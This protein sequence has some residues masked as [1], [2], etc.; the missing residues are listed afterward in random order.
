MTAYELCFEYVEKLRVAVYDED[1]R[2]IVKTLLK[3]LANVIKNPGV[4]KYRL[5]RKSNNS[6]RILTDLYPQALEILT[7]VGFEEKTID[8]EQKL[9][10]DAQKE[11]KELMETGLKV[12]KEAATDLNMAPG[13]IPQVSS[14]NKAQ[15]DQA[16]TEARESSKNKKNFNL[17]KS[18]VQN[19]SGTLTGN[20]SNSRM[21]DEVKA[22]K[23]K[24][25]KMIEDAGIPQRN[26]KIIPSGSGLNPRNFKSFLKTSNSGSGNAETK[27]KSDSAIVLA[28]NK[29]RRDK[30]KKNEK[31]QT[32]AMRE[33]EQLKNT[34]VF[35]RTLI[36][37]QLPDRSVVQA[38]FNPMEKLEAVATEVQKCF[39]DSIG[40]D[41]TF[42]FYTTPPKKKLD[43][44]KRLEEQGLKPAAL[45]YLGWDGSSPT[46]DYLRE[47]L[48]VT[49]E[50]AEEFPSSQP[51]TEADKS[52]GA[53]PSHS[54]SS[55]SKK[56]PASSGK[57]KW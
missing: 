22:L 44:E 24:H 32:K 27:P 38:I 34:R 42:Y 13:D 9:I 23:A 51:L 52:K 17:Y 31:F 35:T 5:I 20:G 29:A 41:K 15:L 2:V 21:E 18:S 12:L 40:N 14:Y 48:F 57:P 37:I 36:R 53:Q 45:I 25:R 26:L 55:S 28:A 6:I 8:R 4:E 7:I 46:G 11:N 30:A 39:V 49:S 1:A 10:L 47:D 56:K 33:M 16:Q 19:I 43:M 50:D 54:S 3:V